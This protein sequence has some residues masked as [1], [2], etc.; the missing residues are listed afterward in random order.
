VSIINEALKKTQQQRKQAKEKRA[1]AVAVEASMDQ[2][3]ETWRSNP[4]PSR[5]ALWM[6]A[7]LLTVAASLAIIE[8]SNYQGFTNI[9]QI[10]L[11]GMN[12]SKSKVSVALDGVIVSD[13]TRIAFINKQAMHVGDVVN[14]MTIV[15][16]NLDTI[17]LQNEKEI[18]ELNTGATYLL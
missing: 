12:K 7:S 13:N 10:V 18:V 16:I 15:A 2:P 17:R 3:E 1:H 8:V 9:K 5:M 6:I 4:N 14:G 11:A